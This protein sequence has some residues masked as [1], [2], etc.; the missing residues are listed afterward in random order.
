MSK[1]TEVFLNLW[2]R[3][4]ESEKNKWDYT[5]FDA[6]LVS[7]M[8][9]DMIRNYNASEAEMVEHLEVLLQAICSLNPIIFYLSSNNACERLIK[10]RQSRGQTPLTNEQIK[11][12]EKRKQTDLPILSRL[13][14]QSHIMDISNDNWNSVI[15]EIVS[16]VTNINRTKKDNCQV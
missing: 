11:F 3:F 16:H 6:S 12:W 2:K 8:T 15:Y 14:A 13:S 10:A 4:A 9:N 7:H 1:F 5:I